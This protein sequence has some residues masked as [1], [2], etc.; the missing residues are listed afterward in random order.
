MLGYRLALHM[1]SGRE[2]NDVKIEIPF[3]AL[4]MVT[5][6]SSLLSGCT[7]PLFSDSF[8]IDFGSASMLAREGGE[9]VLAISGWGKSWFEGRLLEIRREYRRAP[10]T[11]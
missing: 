2:S 10:H 6:T 5:T 4:S 11:S 1:V 9:Q 3:T 8:T 7:L